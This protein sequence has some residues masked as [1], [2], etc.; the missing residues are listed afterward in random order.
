VVLD[1][2]I[3][4]VK[5]MRLLGV[6]KDRIREGGEDTVIPGIRL[7]SQTRY[8]GVADGERLMILNGHFNWLVDAL[9]KWGYEVPV[10]TEQLLT[11]LLDAGVMVTNPNRKDFMV[12][13][14]DR[15][16]GCR[17]LLRRKVSEQIGHNFDV[18]EIPYAPDAAVTEYPDLELP[19]TESDF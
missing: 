8:V 15:T 17:V 13:C 2:S 10:K 11:L 4:F 1:L 3:G 5:D 18:P 9:R 19:S 7:P 12:K 16:I 6:L 14:G